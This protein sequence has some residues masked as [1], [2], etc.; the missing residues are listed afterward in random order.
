MHLV[1]VKNQYLEVWKKYVPALKREKITQ[2]LSHQQQEEWVHVCIC[3][4][5]LKNA[6]EGDGLT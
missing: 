2:P 4:F 6:W 5:Q 3:S 1:I